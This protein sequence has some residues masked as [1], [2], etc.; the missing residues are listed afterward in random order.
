MTKD[1]GEGREY[2]DP[3][4]METVKVAAKL[5]LEM[6]HCHI[7]PDFV[8][9]GTVWEQAMKDKTFL[10]EYCEIIRKDVDPDKVTYSYG[11]RENM[12]QA[13]CAAGRK[14]EIIGP[15]PADLVSVMVDVNLL[16]AAYKHVHRTTGKD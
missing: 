3:R 11:S 5:A 12:F 16:E 7:Q 13:I 8:L 4:D 14:I 2:L 1:I 9:L 10:K 15:N 6:F